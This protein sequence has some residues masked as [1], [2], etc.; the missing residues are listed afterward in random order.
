MVLN[1]LPAQDYSELAGVVLRQ[2]KRKEQILAGVWGRFLCLANVGRPQDGTV[3][4]PLLVLEARDPNRRWRRSKHAGPEE[5][6]ELERLEGDGHV[7]RR[8]HS[9][10]E[11]HSSLEAVRATQL[12][13][14]LPHEI[15]HLVDYCTQVPRDGLDADRCF[16]L[17][18]IYWR[19][20]VQEKE[21]FAHRYADAFRARM[22]TEGKLPFPRIESWDDDGLRQS[23]FLISG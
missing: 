6:A 7:L 4:G 11:V 10:T 20:P 16:E 19:L 14:T 5:A 23:D 12:Y 15:G 22:Q 2:P 18:Q 17:A 9:Q 1:W 13:R 3:E 21:S 8:T